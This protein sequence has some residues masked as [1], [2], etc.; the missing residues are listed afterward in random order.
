MTSFA[1]EAYS[2]NGVYAENSASINDVFGDHMWPGVN[3]VG[4]NWHLRLQVTC[5]SVHTPPYSAT[6]IV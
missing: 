5:L 3:T 6:C 1:E 2:D 4:L